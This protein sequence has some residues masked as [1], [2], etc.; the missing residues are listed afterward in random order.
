MKTKENWWGLFDEEGFLREVTH[1]RL[2]PNPQWKWKIKKVE[3]SYF[4]TSV[5]KPE[6]IK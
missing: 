3:V 4:S 1:N 5:E 6:E 2:I